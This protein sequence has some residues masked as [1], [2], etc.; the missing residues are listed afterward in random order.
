MTQLNRF[1]FADWLAPMFVV[2]C[3]VYRV[4]W[5]LSNT[6]N[7]SHTPLTISANWLIATNNNKIQYTQTHTDME[8]QPAQPL[9]HTHIIVYLLYNH[10][11]VSQSNIPY[12]DT[13]PC[14]SLVYLGDQTWLD[15]APHKKPER[16]REREM[17]LILSSLRFICQV[18]G[19]VMYFLR[20]GI[21]NRL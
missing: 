10:E 12:L 6:A 16:E 14:F 19:S 5:A 2:L 13:D 3:S 7:I 1:A 20:S 11:Q 9:S 17:S 4:Q 15:Y 18:A 8:A 21:L